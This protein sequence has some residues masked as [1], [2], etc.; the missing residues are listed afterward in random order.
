MTLAE[1]PTDEL[2]GEL[3]RR[4]AENLASADPAATLT[5]I[6]VRAAAAVYDIRPACV[7]GR[8]KSRPC[9]Y[10]RWA[11]WHVMTLDHRQTF[12]HLGRLFDRDH[13][14][15]MHG[16]RE[17]TNLILVCARFRRAVFHIR[18]SLS[19]TPYNQSQP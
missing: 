9:V 3:A 1:I 10:A 7:L 19:S 15:V 12:A 8:S 18:E 6:C 14:A 16:C 17:A 11:A 4:K 2:R 13:A 5:A